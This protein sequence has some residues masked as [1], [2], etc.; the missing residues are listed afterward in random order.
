M[1]ASGSGYIYLRAALCVAGARAMPGSPNRKTW[2][3]GFQALDFRSWG[4]R[5]FKAAGQSKG[6]SADTMMLMAMLI[7]MVLVIMLLLRVTTV[8]SNSNKHVAWEVGF[9]VGRGSYQ[10]ICKGT[11]RIAVQGQSSAWLDLEARNRV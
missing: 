6:I 3:V 7:L 4:V 9:R 5:S 2:E 11:T 8:S 1:G 10:R